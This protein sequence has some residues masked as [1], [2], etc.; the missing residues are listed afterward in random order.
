MRL[1]NAFI[2]LILT[3]SSCSPSQKKDAPPKLTEKVTAPDSSHYADLFPSV[4]QDINKKHSAKNGSYYMFTQFSDSSVKITWGNKNI[5]RV[6]DEPL[7]FM[8]AERISIKW[9]NKDYLILDYFTGS[10]AWTNVALPLNSD[11]KVQEFANGLYFD[12]KDNY[13][14]TEEVGDPILS[15]HNLKTQ[16]EQFVSELYRPCESSSNSACIETISIHNKVLHYKWVTPRT[17]LSPNT[18]YERQVPLKI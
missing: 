16:K 17:D 3:L 5:K 8:F 4:I 1:S 15:V 11:E 18:K 2:C 10:G 7:D 13:L 6:Y 9:Q 14:I 12:K